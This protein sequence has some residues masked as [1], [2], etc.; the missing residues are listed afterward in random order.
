MVGGGYLWKYFDDPSL[1][2]TPPP[3]RGQKEVKVLV[4]FEG[5]NGF[6]DPVL[7]NSKSAHDYAKLV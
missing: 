6:L 4:R 5:G 2:S 7:S 1:R 3:F